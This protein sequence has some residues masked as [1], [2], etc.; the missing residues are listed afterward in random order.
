M[1]EKNRQIFEARQAEIRRR[2]AAGKKPSAIAAWLNRLGS[3]AR[4]RR[5]MGSLS[6]L[7][8]GVFQVLF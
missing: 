5:S 1:Q 3:S 8:Q 7:F 2:L 4:A 6:R